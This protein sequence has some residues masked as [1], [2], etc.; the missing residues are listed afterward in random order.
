MKFVKTKSITVITSKF[1]DILYNLISCL[2]SSIFYKIFLNCIHLFSVHQN[3]F[4]PY[5]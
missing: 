1:N 4:I 5:F 2:F 3:V